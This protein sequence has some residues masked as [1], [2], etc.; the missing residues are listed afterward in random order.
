MIISECRVE[1]T[2]ISEELNILHEHLHHIDHVDLNMRKRDAQMS[3]CSPE[4]FLSRAVTIE[5]TLLQPR[6]KA[7]II[8]LET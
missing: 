8:R 2:E 4:M 1:L 3:K 5:E 7:A 6:N